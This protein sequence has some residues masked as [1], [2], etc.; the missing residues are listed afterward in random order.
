M[1]AMVVFAIVIFSFDSFAFPNM[2]VV[3]GL[4]T[5]A[6]HLADPSTRPV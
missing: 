6:A 3:F 1:L 4:I 5:S 2:W